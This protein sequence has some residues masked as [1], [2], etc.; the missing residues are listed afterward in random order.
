MITTRIRVSDS[1]A[2]ELFVG[3]YPCGSYHGDLHLLCRPCKDKVSSQKLAS[4][5]DAVVR[6]HAE[7]LAKKHPDPRWLAALTAAAKMLR[8]IK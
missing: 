8:R 3:R 7:E 4:V 2:C 6:L 1:P 5:K